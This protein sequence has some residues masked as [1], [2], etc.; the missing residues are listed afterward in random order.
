MVLIEAVQLSGT[1]GAPVIYVAVAVLGIARAF[2]IPT[3]AAIIPNLVPRNEVQTRDGLVCFRQPDRA[4]RRDAAWRGDLPARPVS[5]LRRCHPAV[6]NWRL[7]LRDP[8]RAGVALQRAVQPGLAA[9][10]LPFRAARPHHSRHA[11]AR[12]VRRVSR[13]RDRAASGLRPRHPADRAVGTG[14]AAG[15]ARRLARWSCRSF[16]RAAR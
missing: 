16:W 3:M 2:E 8:L 9:R 4:D 12:Y 14:P 15:G 7:Y 13:R 5:G 11:V 10:R 6:G 1:L